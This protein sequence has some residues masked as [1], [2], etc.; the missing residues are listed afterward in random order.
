[1]KHLRTSFLVVLMAWLGHSTYGQQYLLEPAAYENNTIGLRTGI[2][3]FKESNEVGTLTGIYSIY[4]LVDLGNAWSF[5]GEIPIILAKFDDGDFSE[6]KTMAWAIF[7][8]KP[9]RPLMRT[10]LPIFRW[11]SICLLLVKITT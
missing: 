3:L 11:V 4:A 10:K 5:F 6:S 9:E 2:P 1:M 8:L 7:S